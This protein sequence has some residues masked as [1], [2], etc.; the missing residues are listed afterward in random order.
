MEIKLKL[1]LRFAVIMLMIGTQR[2][3]Q[4][5]KLTMVSLWKVQFLGVPDGEEISIDFKSGGKDGVAHRAQDILQINATGTVDLGPLNLR[6]SAV[7]DNN[8][9]ESNSLPI[10]YMFNGETSKSERKLSALQR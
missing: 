9:Y 5:S 4:I 3:I 8:T 7:V 6:L 1:S 2:T 10:Y